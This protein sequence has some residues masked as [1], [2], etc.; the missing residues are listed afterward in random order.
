MLLAEQGDARVT[1]QGSS[2]SSMGIAVC[3]HRGGDVA[4]TVVDFTF[5]FVFVFVSM[6]LLQ[7]LW[8]RQMRRITVCPP[9]RRPILVQGRARARAMWMRVAVIIVGGGG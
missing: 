5:V 3:R 6:F 1:E 9:A 4:A 8:Q 2:S 7:Q